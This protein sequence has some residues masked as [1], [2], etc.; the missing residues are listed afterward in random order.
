MATQLTPNIP[1][2]AALK[3]GGAD[4]PKEQLAEAAALSVKNLPR[5]MSRQEAAGWITA[6]GALTEEGE[7]ALA[8]V[9]IGGEQDGARPI[10]AAMIEPSPFNPRKTFDKDSIATLA[11]A[12]QAQGQLQ[13]ILV[14]PHP[15]DAN[16]F[17]IIAGERRWRAAMLLTGEKR[18]I[19]DLEFGTILADVRDMDD[20]AAF[21]AAISENADREDISPLE[22][23]E[24]L[25]AAVE[26]G[27]GTA[28]DLAEAL[29]RPARNVQQRISLATKLSETAKQALVENVL[30]VSMARTLAGHHEDL[31]QKA[32]EHIAKA[33]NPPSNETELKDWIDRQG[34]RM[35]R[36]AFDRETYIEREGRLSGD[37]RAEICLDKDLAE[38][39]QKA[40][41]QELVEAKA[42]ELKLAG[43]GLVVRSFWPGDWP[44]PDQK[45]TTGDGDVFTDLP[46]KT[47]KPF[48]CAVAAVNWNTLEIRIMA[49]RVNSKAM[50]EAGISDAANDDD[51]DHGAHWS[52]KM[53]GAGRKARSA[54]LASGL[55]A[56]AVDKPQ[57]GLALM[58]LSYLTHAEKD[59]DHE[60]GE[61]NDATDLTGL[62]QE[63]A[64]LDVE[65]LE[66]MAAEWTHTAKHLKSM[67]KV[68]PRNAGLVVREGAPLVTDWTKALAWLAVNPN[69]PNLLAAMIADFT[70]YAASWGAGP[71]AGPIEIALA[72]L[73]DIKSPK[74]DHAEHLKT[75]GLPEL[76]A[77]ANAHEIDLKHPS[78]EALTRAALEKALPKGWVP[79]EAKFIPADK[80]QA[81]I[82]ALTGADKAS[83]DEA[84]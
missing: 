73:L 49:P 44:A 52:Y 3:R 16:R 47:T 74:I 61:G 14:R 58:A 64:T 67:I 82:D 11:D 32:C 79:P 9:Q 66:R 59:P 80:A 26:R 50:R 27:V 39:L 45:S 55:G 5:T 22:E 12:L 78:D 21:T 40:K 19:R 77:L 83:M 13:A 60:F 30:T 75:Y 63:C 51:H 4:Q 65:N 76:L 46:S 33:W 31:Q 29:G 68:A 71:G 48:W 38:E 81:E 34:V 25:A 57:I 41:A 23:G 6:D 36:M 35:A 10:V 2:L 70:A 42:E 37:R 62:Y 17:E 53:H 24:A 7:A 69:L 54:T 28:K 72:D 18:G 56:A 84:A 1:L 15:S 20:A 43:G 8:S